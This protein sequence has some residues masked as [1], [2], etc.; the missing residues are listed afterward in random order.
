MKQET[1]KL[2]HSTGV[3]NHF[4]DLVS[5]DSRYFTQMQLQKLVY[6][7]HGWHL[8]IFNSGLT[9]DEP[10]AWD[11]GPLYRNLWVA[12]RKYGS[13]PVTE[14][15]RERDFAI[16]LTNSAEDNS[17]EGEKFCHASL[18]ADQE[19]LLQRIFDVYGSLQAFE[20][21]A[22][23]HQEGTPWYIVFVDKGLKREKIPSDIIKK[24]FVSIA[25]KAN[26]AK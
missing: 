23:T 14:K 1:E 9:S 17:K 20:L 4:L 11:Y 15:I 13:N 12:I 19:K 6:V 2:V 26:E 8:A 21:S 18:N 7:S 16:D 3:A 25:E 22:L 10:E 5:R 24:H